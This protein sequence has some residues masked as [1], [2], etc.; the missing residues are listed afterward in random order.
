MSATADTQWP[1]DAL[2]ADAWVKALAE[3]PLPIGQD[4]GHGDRVELVRG[5]HGQPGARYEFRSQRLTRATVTGE[6]SRSGSGLRLDVTLAGVQRRSGITGTL[7][8]EGARFPERLTT[9][10][11]IGPLRWT[12]EGSWQ[13]RRAEGSASLPWVQGSASGRVTR[14][15]STDTLS[16]NA[17]FSGRGLTRALSGLVA[18]FGGLSIR[19]GF[20]DGVREA[21]EDLAS[22]ARGEDMGRGSELELA[23]LDAHA[24]AIRVAVASAKE[25]HRALP[26]WRRNQKRWRQIV[27]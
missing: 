22:F 27:K 20:T 25:Q 21:A 23:R 1:D 10:G 19:E 7:R 11:R 8:V 14:R 3:D 26:F 5:I 4:L 6:L 15:G 24:L 9:S 12:A 18:L 16:A 13:Q 2:V 17:A